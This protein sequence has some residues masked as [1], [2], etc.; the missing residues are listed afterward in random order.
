[1]TIAVDDPKRTVERLADREI[2]V[3]S[4]PNPDAIRASI[5]AVNSRAD[6]DALLEALE[7]EF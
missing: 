1:V 7:A 4:L 5:H 2:V 6:V 3:R